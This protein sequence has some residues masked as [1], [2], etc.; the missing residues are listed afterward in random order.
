MK[1]L[2][3]ITEKQLEAL[4]EER[5]REASREA[6]RGYERDILMKQANI[7]SLQ[8]QI[9]PHFL[10]NAL[11]CIRGQALIDGSEAVADMTHALSHF[12]RYSISSKSNVVTLANE[13]ENVRNY[14]TIQK[15]RFRDRFVIAYEMDD[16]ELNNALLPK[17]TLQ[18]IVENAIIHGFSDIV[19]GGEITVRVERLDGNV[20]VKVSDNGKGMP[21]EVLE[22]LNSAFRKDHM[23]V[24]ELQHGYDKGTGVGMANVDRRIK[25]YFGVDYGLTINSC[26]GV[27]TD[28]EVFFPY[29]LTV[30]QS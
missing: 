8:S 18:P 16:P 24:S 20:S 9:N 3:L 15:H 30:A 14:I 13:L 17:L 1:G 11:E 10:Y 19:S 4:V 5:L 2:R 28:V 7:M 21:A 12:F 6:N 27:G 22:R 23:S 25:L 26:A 29:T